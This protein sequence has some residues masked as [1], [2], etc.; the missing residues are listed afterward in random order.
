MTEEE[1][2]IRIHIDAG[3]RMYL[4]A[5]GFLDENFESSKIST[6]EELFSMLFRWYMSGRDSLR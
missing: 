1:R 6:Q 2:Q 4:D 5:Y 3:R